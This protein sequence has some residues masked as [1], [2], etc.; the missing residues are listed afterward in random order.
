MHGRT[1]DPELEMVS[2]G[3]GIRR[4]LCSA[5]YSAASYKNVDPQLEGRSSDGAVRNKFVISEMHCVRFAGARVAESPAISPHHNW[6]TFTIEAL[7]HQ[8]GIPGVCNNPDWEGK[9]DSD[10]GP[11][12]ACLSL[13]GPSGNNP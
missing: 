12:T 5:N 2:T 11:A 13:N 3:C 10:A 4:N 1:K 7:S 6:L 9:S 8:V